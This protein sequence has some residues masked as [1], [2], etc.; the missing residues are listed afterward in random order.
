MAVQGAKWDSV[1]SLCW[2]QSKAISGKYKTAKAP[3]F[4]LVLIFTA[5][6]VKNHNVSLALPADRKG[7]AR[8][9]SGPCTILLQSQEF[10]F[11]QGTFLWVRWLVPCNS[12]PFL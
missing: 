3:G 12:I 11:K 2:I 7:G 6:I 5:S 8:G 9:P 4:L 1:P 10:P